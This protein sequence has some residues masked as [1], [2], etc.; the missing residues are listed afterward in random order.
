MILGAMLQAGGSLWSMGAG[1]TEMERLRGERM[2]ALRLQQGQ[3]LGEARATAGA[4][5]VE[6]SSESIQRHL[7]TMQQEFTLQQTRLENAG[8]QAALNMALSYGL[9]G[10]SDVGRGVA[11]QGAIENWWRK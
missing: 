11:M 10:V 2:R 6:Y 3:K 4:S 5:G 8:D 9:Q 1:L 7:Q